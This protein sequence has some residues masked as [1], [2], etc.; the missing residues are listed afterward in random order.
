MNTA[1]EPERVAPIKCASR[2]FGCI[3]AR[4]YGH[5][6]AMSTKNDCKKRSNIIGTIERA[7]SRTSA[8]VAPGQDTGQLPPLHVSTEKSAKNSILKTPRL[9]LI[10]SSLTEAPDFAPSNDCP[11]TIMHQNCNSRDRQDQQL[12][13]IQTVVESK[14][15]L[16]G[17][18]CKASLEDRPFKL[19]GM[20]SKVNSKASTDLK[21]IGYI[22]LSGYGQISLL[23]YPSFRDAG[24][25]TEALKA[26]LS[27]G[28]ASLEHDTLQVWIR[29]ENNLRMERVAEKMGMHMGHNRVWTLSKREYDNLWSPLEELH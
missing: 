24:F 7:H 11:I 19:S 18:L 1:G 23:I 10:P 3:G 16:T 8:P 14:P 9:S 21:T 25:G 2:H 4:V 5:L 29:D 17:S 12:W 20:R 28:F 22:S 27:H 6:D 15:K 13:V 26:V